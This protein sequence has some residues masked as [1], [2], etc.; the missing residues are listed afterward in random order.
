MY[1]VTA[2]AAGNGYATKGRKQSSVWGTLTGARQSAQRWVEN[3]R[4]GPALVEIEEVE[5]GEPVSF[6]MVV[7][8][9]PNG[10]VRKGRCNQ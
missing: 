4:F 3:A 10:C 2:W 7:G 1:R 8:E 9:D 5:T 6:E